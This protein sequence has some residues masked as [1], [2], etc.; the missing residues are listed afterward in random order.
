[1]VLALVMANQKFWHY[2]EFHPVTVVMN[3]PIQQILSKPNLSGRLT[4]W[5]VGKHVQ[6]NG[7]LIFFFLKHKT[8]IIQSHV[9]RYNKLLI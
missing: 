2:F 7:G 9:A 3:F 8:K 4:K 6:R 1:M 5:A